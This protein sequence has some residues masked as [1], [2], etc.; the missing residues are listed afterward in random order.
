[1]LGL[2]LSA[3]HAQLEEHLPLRASLVPDMVQ[4]QV[5][6]DH[7]VPVAVEQLTRHMPRHIGID[8]SKVLPGSIVDSIYVL[9]DA[10]D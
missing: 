9:Q 3:P 6:H 5:M 7:G 8:F 1:M 4:T 2:E 10:S